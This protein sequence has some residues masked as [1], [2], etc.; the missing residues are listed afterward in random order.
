M[1]AMI[2]H[3]YVPDFD[4]AHPQGV[5]MESLESFRAVGQGQMVDTPVVHALFEHTALAIILYVL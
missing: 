3:N 4:G 2:G 1:L 5:P